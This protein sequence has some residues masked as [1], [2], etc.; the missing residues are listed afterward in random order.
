MNDEPAYEVSSAGNTNR[1]KPNPQKKVEGKNP[2]QKLTSVILT[3]HSI[4]IFFVNS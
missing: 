3:N 1:P 4:F 2:E